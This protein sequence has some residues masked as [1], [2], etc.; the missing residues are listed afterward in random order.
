MNAPKGIRIRD[1]IVNIN[2]IL[3]V[4]FDAN[5]ENTDADDRCSITFA[6]GDVKLDF[7]GSDAKDIYHLLATQMGADA[8]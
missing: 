6:G 2:N 1:H 8:D 7:Y 5:D 3:H 4:H